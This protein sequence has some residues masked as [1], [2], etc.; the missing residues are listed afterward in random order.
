MTYARRR[1]DCPRNGRHFR[2][3]GFTLIELMIV[4]V[5]VAILA[6]IAYPSYR[7]HVLKA[8]RSDAKIALTQLAQDEERFYSQYNAYTD[9]IVGPTG[10]SG[11]ACG[12]SYGSNK[13]PQRFYTLS[14]N[15]GGG[16]TGPTFTAT[17][18]PVTGQP[19]GSDTGCTSFTLDNTGKQGATG[20]S[21]GS[22]W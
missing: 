22:C 17:A 18:S 5:I 16:T 13:S 12:L 2:T 20:S 1:Q 15:V 11:S 9:V 21:A 4:V 3:H 19:T 10:C 8:D 14:V 7:Q 6:A